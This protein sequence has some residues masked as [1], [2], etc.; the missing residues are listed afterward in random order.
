LHVRLLDTS[1]AP[2]EARMVIGVVKRRVPAKFVT[3]HQVDL[4]TAAAK[5]STGVALASISPLDK[6]DARDAATACVANIDLHT[7]G[8]SQ[9]SRRLFATHTSVALAWPCVSPPG[10]LRIGAWLHWG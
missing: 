5:G 4:T 7:Q 10:G 6:V 1:E 2:G 3:F 8:F 9:Q